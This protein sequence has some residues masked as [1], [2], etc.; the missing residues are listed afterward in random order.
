MIEKKVPMDRRHD[1][2]YERLMKQRI[3]KL[4]NSEQLGTDASLPFPNEPLHTAALTVPK[5]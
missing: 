2:F 5:K 1:D 3:Q 4:I